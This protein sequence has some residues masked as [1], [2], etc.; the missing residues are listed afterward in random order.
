RTGLRLT[1]D[2]DLVLVPQHEYNDEN[3][4]PLWETVGPL[5]TK[6]GAVVVPFPVKGSWQEDLKDMVR[7]G[8]DI[9]VFALGLVTGGSVTKALTGVQ[10]AK[11]DENYELAGLVVHARPSER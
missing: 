5:L 1:G 6:D 10:E 9:L 11:N 2:A 3:F 8:R 7:A 4:M